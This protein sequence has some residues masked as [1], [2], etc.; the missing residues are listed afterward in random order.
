MP[1]TA[2]KEA[3]FKTIESVTC[4]IIPISISI[5]AG[6]IV[7]WGST[8]CG[9]LTEQHTP[10]HRLF[11]VVEWTENIPPSISQT[12]PDKV[13]WSVVGT[14]VRCRRPAGH[15]ERAPRGLEGV[16]SSPA[17]P[18]REEHRETDWISLG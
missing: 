4:I 8:V 11:C 18:G 5:G 13:E 7:K 9:L 10:L 2:K 1:S 16:W 14:A 12:E 15:F 3:C 6:R 17:A